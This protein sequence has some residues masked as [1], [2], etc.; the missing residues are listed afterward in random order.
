MKR[1]LKGHDNIFDSL[2]P[3]PEIS[4]LHSVV[5]CSQPTT[6]THLSP[7]GTEVGQCAQKEDNGTA[8]VSH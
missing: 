6:D 4:A 8:P 3:K 7:I 2:I 1:I 5:Y